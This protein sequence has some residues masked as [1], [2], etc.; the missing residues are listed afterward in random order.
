MTGFLTGAAIGAVVAAIPLVLCL[1]R[2]WPRLRW[3][4]ADNMAFVRAAF[5]AGFVPLLFLLSIVI[6]PPPVLFA[7][8]WL[9]VVISAI[10]P[11]VLI[12]PVD[13][14]IPLDADVAAAIVIAQEAWPRF[15]GGD[16][17]GAAAD[18]DR[19]RAVRTPATARYVELWQRFLSEQ[20]SRPDGSVPLN[21]ETLEEIRQETVRI[22]A[23]GPYPSRKRS[24]AA[25]AL[26]GII[27]ASPAL[28]NARACIGV[29]FLLPARAI[30]AAGDLPLLANA[31]M[32]LPEPG[33]E[34]VLESPLTLEVAAESRHDP[35]THYQLLEAGYLAGWTRVWLMQNGDQI[36]S[37]VFEFADEAGALQYQEQVSRHACQYSNEGFGTP[38]GGIG[39]QVRYGSGPHPIVEQV[40]WVIGTRRHVISVGT[41]E[42][43]ED[44]TRILRLAEQAMEDA[45]G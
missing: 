7:F 42:A 6:G 38:D 33:A 32:P 37:D 13:D 29:E 35:A 21:G 19:L 20:R 12:G 2:V 15:E 18:I 16:L 43:P 17:D 34:L 22:W 1:Y 14:R 44:H 45:G 39:L 30:E 41:V 31:H 5:V 4:R 11:E 23:R 24:W 9:L 27:G 8:A 26:A 40:S 3:H 10:R 25:I 28:V 36:E